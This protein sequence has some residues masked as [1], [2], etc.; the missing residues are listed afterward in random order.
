MFVAVFTKNRRE[1]KKKTREN[2]KHSRTRG[3][4][5]NKNVA[6]RVKAG[7]RW[8]GGGEWGGRNDKRLF[9]LLIDGF[10]PAEKGC[11]VM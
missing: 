8:E 7:G 2:D 6:R 5:K 9:A 1:K 11:G 4:V 10:R 3:F